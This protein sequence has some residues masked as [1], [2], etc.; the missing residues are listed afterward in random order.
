VN[1]EIDSYITKIQY[2]DKGLTLNRL[3]EAKR[4]GV[5]IKQK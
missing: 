4:D 3:K 1:K 5:G 2:K